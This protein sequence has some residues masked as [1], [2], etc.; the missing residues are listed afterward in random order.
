MAGER[1]TL[2]LPRIEAGVG[3]A[4]DR[5]PPA[6]L[7]LRVCTMG[8]ITVPAVWPRVGHPHAEGWTEEQPYDLAHL[9]DLTTSH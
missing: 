7:S 9:Q 3:L 5:P 6:S 4:R 8:L 2:G 1:R